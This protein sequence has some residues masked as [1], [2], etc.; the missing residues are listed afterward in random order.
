MRDVEFYL[1]R[2]C[3]F[4]LLIYWLYL[5]EIMAEVKGII[6]DTIYGISESLDQRR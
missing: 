1:I 5:F 6:E 2:G 3:S 4:G